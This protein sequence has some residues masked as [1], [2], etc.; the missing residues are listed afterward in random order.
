M[1][2][3]LKEI[4]PKV[5]QVMVL[6]LLEG[7]VQ[8]VAELSELS[9]LIL[10]HLFQGINRE[11]AGLDLIIHLKSFIEM[12]YLQLLYVGYPYLK[13]LVILFSP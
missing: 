11:I 3:C 1:K 5:I 8:F 10:E 13:V 12:Q 9:L 2:E 4:D 7:L 6:I